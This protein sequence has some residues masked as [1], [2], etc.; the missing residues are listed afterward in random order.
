MPFFDRDEAGQ[1]LAKTLRRYRRQ[2]PVVLALPRG[3]VAVAAPIAWALA[4][5]LDLLIVRKIGVPGQPELAMGAIVDGAEPVVVHNQQVIATLGIS[6][7][8]FGEVRDRELAE[9]ERRRRLYLANRSFPDIAGRTV[10]VVDDGIATGATMKA[11]LEALRTR[12]PRRLVM[13]VPVAPKDT[14]EELRP[15]ADDVICIESQAAFMAISAYYIKFDQVSDA[16][17][18]DTLAAFPPGDAGTAAGT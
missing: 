15:L 16:E 10:I 13:A 9:I 14:L 11:A 1:R 5:P 18:I 7:K 12:R 3:G 2:R 4:A 6:D 17:V 8:E